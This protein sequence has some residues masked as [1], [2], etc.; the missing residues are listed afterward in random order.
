MD[1]TIATGEGA[2]AVA[3]LPSPAPSWFLRPDGT[4]G[5][6]TIHGVSHTLR[7]MVHATEIAQ[8]LAVA[9]W[10]REAVLLAALWHDIGRTHDGGDFH[11]GAKSAGKVVGLMLHRGVAPRVLEAALH[12]VT[13]HSSS[14]E[15][16]E[17]AAR[18]FD[19]PEAVRR[20]FRI[21]KDGDGLDRVRL[22]DLDVAQLRLPISRR[23][24][25]RAEEL[26]RVVP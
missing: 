9:E 22:G 5:S 17:R 6:R 11:H 15:H 18:H 8:A 21:L 14:E 24:V 1:D 25:A 4:D 13:H 12:A 2:A 20:V 7:V 19:D 16:G 3:H 26:L 23:R 10:E